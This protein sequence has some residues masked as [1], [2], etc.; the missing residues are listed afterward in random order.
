MRRHKYQDV[1]EAMLLLAL[2]ALCAYLGPVV[3]HMVMR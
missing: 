2:F 3:W 1:Y